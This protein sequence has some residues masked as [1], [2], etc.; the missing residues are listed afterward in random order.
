[1]N[2][3]GQSAEAQAHVT[4]PMQAEGHETQ[5]YVGMLSQRPVGPSS[6]PGGQT[7]ASGNTMAPPPTCDWTH[8]SDAGQLVDVQCPDPDPPLL[9]VLLPPVLEASAPP[10][11]SFE[12]ICTDPE[13]P[14]AKQAPQ[15]AARSLP[16]SCVSMMAFLPPRK[17]PAAASLITGSCRFRREGS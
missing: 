5:A 14:R 15:S 2:D 12:P 4:V 16:A 6:R 13:Q 1:M 7:P 17:S 11:C 10:S 9:D 8:S 3:C